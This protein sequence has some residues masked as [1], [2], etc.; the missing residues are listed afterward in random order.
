MWKANGR[1]VYLRGLEPFPTTID[2]SV[3]KRQR[4]LDK[5]QRSIRAEGAGFALRTDGTETEREK[6]RDE[7]RCSLRT[8]HG[9][10]EAGA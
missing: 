9:G 3:A 6:K 8:V 2:A 1:P 7:A 10:L 4:R 5:R